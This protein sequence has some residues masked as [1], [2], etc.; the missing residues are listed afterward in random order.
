[1]NYF[2]PSAIRARE[3]RAAMDASLWDS[4]ADLLVSDPLTDENPA[5]VPSGGDDGIGPA[6]MLDFGAYFDL[7]LTPPFGDAVSPAAK[8]AAACRLRRRLQARRDTDAAAAAPY[9]SNFSE[10]DYSADERACMARWWD[11]EPANRMAMAAASAA[12]L[13]H[14]RSLIDTAFSHLRAASPELCAE[15]ETIVRDI[16]LSRPDPA[17]NRMNYGGASSF[18]LWGAL[19]INVETQI[20]WLQIYRQI[21]HEAG[22]NLLFGV[23][24][25]E[26]LVGDDASVRVTSPIRADPR[27]MD[28]V[29]HAAFVSAREALAFDALLCRHEAVGCLS[30]GDAAML[31]DLLRISVLAFFDCRDTLRGQATL[32]PLGDAI[33]ADCE[34]Y[35]T[36]N[37]AVTTQ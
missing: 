21:V 27:P 33:L 8:A 22:H 34:D 20:E 37:F 16:V 7:S 11:I 14:A 29:Y 26:P 23:A 3:C 5:D 28:G 24:R 1:M 18:A 15:I 17:H 30:S 31:A 12:E 19:T 9:V 13:A 4:A 10:E 32:T 35:M 6:R 36:A 25:E 2:E